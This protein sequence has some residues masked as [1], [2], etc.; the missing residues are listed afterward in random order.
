MMDLGE[1]VA[2]PEHVLIDNERR[3]AAGPV[4]AS[5][6]LLADMRSTERWCWP[7]PDGPAAGAGPLLA[8][9]ITRQLPTRTSHLNKA[10][11]VDAETLV[12]TDAWV[13]SVAPRASIVATRQAAVPLA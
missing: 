11:L 1:A 13:R 4:A 10:D 12:A 8:D 7:T 5:L 6:S 2:A 3:R 9:T